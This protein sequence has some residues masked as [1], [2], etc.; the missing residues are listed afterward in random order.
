[1]SK[2]HHL[3]DQADQKCLDLSEQVREMKLELL[4]SNKLRD[5]YEDE[6]IELRPKVQDQV[7]AFQGL[8]EQ[9][10]EFKN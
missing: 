9:L 4:E 1:M 2:L 10:K 5:K 6:L 3:I 8:Q 7:Y